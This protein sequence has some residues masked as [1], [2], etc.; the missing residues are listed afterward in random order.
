[1]N[2]NSFWSKLR[3][4]AEN[5]FVLTPYLIPQQEAESTMREAVT[6]RGTNLII[7]V[8]AIFIASLGLNTNSTAVII[9]AMLISPL[10]GPIIGIGL[11]IGVTDF[12]LVKRSCRNL[13]IAALFSVLASTLYFLISPVAEGHSE[14]LARTSPTIYDVLI[15]LIGGGAGIVGICSKSKGNV[16]PG[17]A[18]ATALMPPLCTAGYGIATL[19]PHYFLGATYL[20][21]INSIFICLATFI[22]VKAFKF[23]PATVVNPERAKKIRRLVY[24]LAIL[25]LLPS[26]Y[27]TYNML[28]QSRF[29]INASNFINAECQWPDTHVLSST[30]D[31]NN[32]RNKQINLT[33]IGKVLPQ[34][35]LTL[36]LTSR[37]HFYNL[38]GTTIKIIQ[39]GAAF[40][41]DQISSGSVR[42]IYQVSQTALTAK[43]AAIDSLQRELAADRATNSAAAEIIPELK[44]VFPHIRE[45]AITRTVFADPR[46][47][48]LDTLMV[49]MV[50]NEGHLS[51]SHRT[52]LQKYLEARLK[53]SDIRIVEVSASTLSAGNR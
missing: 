21:L 27:L 18:I 11:G 12:D 47:G 4:L 51:H 45:I 35:S 23:K 29:D 16:I 43:Q 15:G 25:T 48:S 20:F 6:F 9:G 31:W 24:T 28:R 8:L 34:D 41:S 49:A 30:E 39:G 10:M 5:Y 19:Q 2:D 14:L 33:L 7:L 40:D 13:I 46:D 3:T 53:V 37:L 32:G 50:N 38:Q 26:I 52:E 44:V 36:A 42:D 17:V 1:M 22:G